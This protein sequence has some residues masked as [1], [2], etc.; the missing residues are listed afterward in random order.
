MAAGDY[1]YRARQVSDD[2]LGL[3]TKDFNDMANTLEENIGKLE[4]GI[5]DRENFVAAFAHELKNA[6]DSNYRL[7]GHAPFP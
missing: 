1:S 4:E 2:E 6:A 7:C 5:Q 3:L